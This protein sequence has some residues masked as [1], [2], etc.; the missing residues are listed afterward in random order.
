MIFDVLENHYLYTP[1]GYNLSAAFNFLLESDLAAL[2]VGRTDLDGDRLY[3]MVQ[4][5]MTKPAVEG[6]WESHRKYIDVQYVYRGREHMGFANLRSMTLGEYNPEKDF[7][8]MADLKISLGNTVE[9]NAGQFVVFFPGEAH[10]P[11]LS[12]VPEPELVKKVVVKVKL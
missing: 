1:I 12:V 2:P 10:K 9:V 8:P 4:E 11:G 7:Q 6:F 5:Y 3:A